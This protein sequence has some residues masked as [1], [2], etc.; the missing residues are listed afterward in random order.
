[1]CVCVCLTVPHDHS[2][3][4][5]GGYP[6]GGANLEATCEELQS[7]IELSVVVETLQSSQTLQTYL[8][9]LQDRRVGGL[10]HRYNYQQLLHLLW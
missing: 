8:S 4:L 10:A 9:L 6:A 2:G 5:L 1:M 7:G 3:V